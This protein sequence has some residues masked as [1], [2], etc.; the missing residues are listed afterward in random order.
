MANK[1]KSKKNPKRP[2][3]QANPHASL[4][5]VEVENPYF[6]KE[7]KESST[8]PKRIGADI[9]VRESAVETLYARKFLATS[10]KRAA[11][12]V[13]ELWEAAGGK[14]S[15]IDYTLDRVDGG[16]GDPVVGRIQAAQELKRLRDLIGFRGYE[17]L[18]KVCCEGK[19][20][21]DLTP[22]KR[23][24]LT[25]ADNLRADLDDAAVMWGMQTKRRSVA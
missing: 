19:A 25:M 1:S 17:I 15:S 24:R 23:E 21:T 20:L 13:R 2:K 6:Q 9:N 16:K 11:D 18:E 7:H 12:K 14:S 5:R 10:Q 3:A 22:H 8:N 4:R